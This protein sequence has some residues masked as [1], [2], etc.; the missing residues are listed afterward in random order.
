MD[1]A[2]RALL[3]KF[4]VKSDSKGI[5]VKRDVETTRVITTYASV[6]LGSLMYYTQQHAQACAIKNGM[7]SLW[8]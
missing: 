8:G 5:S 6:L 4:F 3:G 1:I 2:P 7:N